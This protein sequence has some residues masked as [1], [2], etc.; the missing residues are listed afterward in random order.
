[1]SPKFSDAM[2]RMT[3]ARLLRTISGSVNS[4]RLLKSSSE[5]SRIHTP[6]DTRPQRPLGRVLNRQ[7]GCDH[8]YFRHAVVL[9][10]RQQN[11]CDFR[12]DGQARHLFAEFGQ[13]VAGRGD[14][15]ARSVLKVV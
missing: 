13:A 10:R 7:R 6:A 9:L 14:D 1:M 15:I 11:A 8:Q 3:A 4:V 2:R 12:V 5:N